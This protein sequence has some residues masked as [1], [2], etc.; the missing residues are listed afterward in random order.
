[1][2]YVL[3]VI[4]FVR[5]FAVYN[6]R[7][8]ILLF[9]LHNYSW[10]PVAFMHACKLPDPSVGELATIV[11]FAAVAGTGYGNGTMSGVF[12]RV[13]P[14][15]EAKTKVIVQVPSV[16][17]MS[18]VVAPVDPVLVNVKP[19]IHVVLPATAGSVAAAVAAATSPEV[20]FLGTAPSG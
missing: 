17:V 3:S 19:V 12:M 13:A 1:M 2:V 10:K 14:A 7:H 6:V 8:E 5:F 16:T 15:T 9:A 4:A 11:V 20:A 18:T